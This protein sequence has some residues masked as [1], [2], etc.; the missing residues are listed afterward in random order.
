MA[1]P[2][3]IFIFIGTYPG[4]AQA[5]E[6]YQVVKDLHSAGAVGTYDAAVVTKALN[7]KVHVNKDEMA[8]RHGAWGGAGRRGGGRYL[9]PAFDPRHRPGGRGHRRGRRPPVA[10][11]VP[12]RRQGTR[13]HHRRRPG[14]P[15][16]RGRKQDG[17]G[18]AEGCPEGRKARRQGPRREPE[19]H[20]QRCPGGRR[21]SELNG[22]CW[23]VAR[24]AR[25]DYQVSSISSSVPSS[26]ISN[27][28]FR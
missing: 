13:R 14:R 2:E 24:V 5:Q 17:A 28:T 20:R 21:G 26:S 12:R 23:P 9:V 4:E 18:R 1:K 6:D 27:S 10:R 11:H 25:G 19:G 8:T 3:S 7:G 22:R 16:G 15:R